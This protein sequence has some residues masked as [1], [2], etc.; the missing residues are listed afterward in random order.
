MFKFDQHAKVKD[1]ISGFTGLVVGRTEWDNGCIRYTVAS[2][3][4]D[5]DGK[6]IASEAFDES[7]LVSLHKPNLVDPDEGRARPG[8]PPVYGDP[9]PR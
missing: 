1:I 3:K 6:V 8:G 7:N 9:R 2:Q 4:L 5:K